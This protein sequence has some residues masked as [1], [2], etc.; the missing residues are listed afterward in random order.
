MTELTTSSIP[1]W[2]TIVAWLSLALAVACAAWIT[3][4]L[5]RRPQQMR[6]MNAV[7]PI[8]A[9][10]GSFL[11]V[12][13]YRRYGRAQPGGEPERMHSDSDRRPRWAPVAISTS[14]CGAGCALGDLLAETGVLLF[15]ALATAVG[16]QRLY[17]QKIFAGWIWALIAAY[18]IGVG[19]QY[20]A[21]APMRDQSRWRS[22]A[23]AV[24][25]DTASI[26]AWQ[27]GMYGTMAVIQF[28]I[29]HPWLGGTL[30][31][32]T[33]V[34]WLGMQIAMLVGFACSY[35]VNVVLIRAGVKEAM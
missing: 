2:L 28:A 3:V 4:D 22:L 1:A 35:P 27:I 19:F 34:F 16:W 32:S 15:P 31:A 9:L 12:Q 26:L 33:A 21:I 24:K 10:F 6:V 25:A 8:V 30:P 13:L 23:D 11:W 20:A 7:W 18:V 17:D 29:I 5:T 14:H